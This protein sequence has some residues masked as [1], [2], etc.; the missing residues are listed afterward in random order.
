M[1]PTPP[2]PLQPAP[3]SPKPKISLVYLIIETLGLS[4]LSYVLIMSI[5]RLLRPLQ[6]PAQGNQ[7]LTDATAIKFDAENKD[8]E[9]EDARFA[10]AQFWAGDVPREAEE[11]VDMFVYPEVY[12]RY[13]G[14][15]PKGYVC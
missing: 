10:L 8:R 13:A 6:G 4:L 3:P 7:F 15:L 5:S 14:S 12:D 1:E 9:V 11:I 2:Q